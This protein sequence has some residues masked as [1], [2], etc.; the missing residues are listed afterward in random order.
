MT[1]SLILIA[2]KRACLCLPLTPKSTGFVFR[3]IV[4]YTTIHILLAHSPTG[5]TKLF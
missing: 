2:E 4:L 5:H 1:L 3:T